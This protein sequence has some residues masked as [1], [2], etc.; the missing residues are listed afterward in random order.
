MSDNLALE[1]R[2]R[3]TTGKKVAQLREQGILPAVIY[4]HGVKPQ[5]LE[6][7]ELPFIKVFKQAGES[8][9]ID[10]SVDQEKPAKVLVQDIQYHPVTQKVVHIDFHQ[11]RMTEKITTE[12]SLVFLGEADAIKNLGGVLV[13]NNDTLRISCLPQDL[14]KEVQVD[15]SPLK[16]FED[17]IHVSDIKLPAEIEVLNKPKEVIALVA[18]PRSEKELEELDQAVEEDKAV[19]EVEVTGEESKEEA[20]EGEAEESAK[21][22]AADKKEETKPE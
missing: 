5:S 17:A 8:T 10:L 19:E 15:I 2:R 21:E 11:V 9:L 1:A 20:A 16:T 14:V 4:G 6:V 7:D 3:T 13:K 18:P 22:P 12:I